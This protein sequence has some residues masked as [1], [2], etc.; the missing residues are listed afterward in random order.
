MMSLLF[1]LYAVQGWPMDSSRQG[2]ETVS[3]SY[4]LC[5]LLDMKL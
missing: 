5:S 1:F 4:G 3:D 2:I